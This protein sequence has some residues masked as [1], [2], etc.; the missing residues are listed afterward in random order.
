MASGGHWTRPSERVVGTLAELA[1][2]GFMI[3]H[4]AYQLLRVGG[5]L[6]PLWAV[7]VVQRVSIAFSKHAQGLFTAQLLPVLCAGPNCYIPA[8]NL[9]LSEFQSALFK[10]QPP[11][12]DCIIRFHLSL[13]YAS[14]RQEPRRQDHHR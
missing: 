4:A 5:A 10:R 7:T 12:S 6:T 2:C 3:G 11:T 8:Y 14:L 1:E 9:H 13:S